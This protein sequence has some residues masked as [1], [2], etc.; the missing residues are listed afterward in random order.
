M[1]LAAKFLS[2]F[3]RRE[4]RKQA[5]VTVMMESTVNGSPKLK[6]VGASAPPRLGVSLVVTL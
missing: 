6:R 5:P 3:H 4:E 2:T 1:Q